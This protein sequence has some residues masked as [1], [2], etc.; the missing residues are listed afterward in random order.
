MIDISI[1]SLELEIT[2]KCLQCC[3]HCMRGPAQKINMSKDIIDKIFTTY[4]IK[5]INDIFITGGEP[6]LNHDTLKYFLIYLLNNE[7]N[8]KFIRMIINGLVY[9]QEILYLLKVLQQ[10][11][12]NVKIQIYQDQFHLQVPKENLKKFKKINFVYYYSQIL[13]S[14]DIVQIGNAKVNNL[15][16][17]EIAIKAFESFKKVKDY[18]TVELNNREVFIKDLYLTVNGKFGPIPG[19]ATWEMIDNKYHLDIMKDSLFKN[20][21]IFNPKNHDYS[22]LT[23]TELEEKVLENKGIQRKY[24]KS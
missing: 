11:G 15:G 22:F 21:E 4:H 3:K 14:K 17:K 12:T 6:F 24:I 19:D 18:L 10:T 1:G 2:R 5:S 23:S 9:D 8:V 13:R 20:C 16:S 7:I